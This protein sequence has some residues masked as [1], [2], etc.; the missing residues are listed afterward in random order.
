MQL[1]DNLVLGK[2]LVKC[3]AVR[4]AKAGMIRFV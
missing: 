3:F 4:V 2:G 1:S